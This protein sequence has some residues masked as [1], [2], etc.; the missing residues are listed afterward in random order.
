MKY[1][2]EKEIKRPKPGTCRK[3]PFN[4]MEVGDSFIIGEY[5]REAMCR[6]SNAAR[7]WAKKVE[8]GY[9]FSVRKTEDGNVRIWRIA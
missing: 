1:K 3:Y 7:N 2:I 6:C 8:N 4:K 5:T 9:R